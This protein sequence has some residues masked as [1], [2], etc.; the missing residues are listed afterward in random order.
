[1]STYTIQAVIWTLCVVALW[2]SYWNYSRYID[3][4]RDPEKS[5]QSLQ[6]ALYVSNDGSIGHAEFE[7]IE[8]SHY[9]PYLKC[10]RVTIFS[11][12]IFGV[13]GL[14]LLIA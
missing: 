13:A 12:L 4:K 2:I 6:T 3:A 14:T 10:F 1:M 8:S 9:S 11:S 7:K 5:R